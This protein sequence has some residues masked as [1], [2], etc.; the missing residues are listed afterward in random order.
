MSRIGKQPVPLPEKVKAA[1]SGTTIQV[2]GPKGK[3][4]WR[5]DRALKVTVDESKRQ[6]RVER[7]DDQRRNRALHGLTRALIANMVR[8]VTEGYQRSLE[9]Y[10]TGYSANVQGEKLVIQCGFAKP[11]EKAI[12]SGIEVVVEVPNTRGNDTPARFTVKGCDKQLVGEFA[13]EVRHIRPPEPYQ[14]KGLRYAGEAIR[15][16]AGKTFVSAAAS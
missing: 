3:L 9:L 12:P 13:A 4:E 8:G 10:G 2:E 1:V 7:S 16:K 15:R 5:F 14:G 6:I 11:V